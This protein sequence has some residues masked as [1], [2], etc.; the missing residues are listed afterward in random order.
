MIPQTA[1]HR[2]PVDI[3]TSPTPESINPHIND[4]K[5]TAPLYRHSI[6]K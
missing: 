2:R 4:Q 5:N 1:I 3:T 6:A